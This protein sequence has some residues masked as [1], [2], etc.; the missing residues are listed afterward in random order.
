MGRNLS[1]LRTVG[2]DRAVRGGDTLVSLAAFKQEIIGY[3]QQ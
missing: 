2:G 3:L 1:G